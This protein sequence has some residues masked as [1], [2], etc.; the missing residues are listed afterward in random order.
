MNR[1]P[2]ARSGGTSLANGRRFRQ[3][4][5][6]G[7]IVA[8][9]SGGRV[10]NHAALRG[11]R[12]ETTCN[13]AVRWSSSLGV[14]LAEPACHAGGRGLAF[15]RSQT[16]PGGLRFVHAIP[17]SASLASS[18]RQPSEKT[19]NTPSSPPR[20]VANRGRAPRPPAL[21]GL[22]FGDRFEAFRGGSDAFKERVQEAEKPPE[23]Q[24]MRSTK[25][26]S[27]IT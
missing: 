2:R 24:G 17:R 8:Q 9:T 20:S 1:L 14:V 23:L 26:V 18:M 25:R 10:T 6:G 12:G 5:F 27:H 19:M 4:R 13:D 7:P 16:K 22:G 11:R 21:L 15:R 3:D